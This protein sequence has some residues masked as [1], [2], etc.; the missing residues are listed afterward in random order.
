MAQIQSQIQSAR[1]GV[2]SVCCMVIAEKNRLPMEL[3][4]AEGLLGGA[5]GDTLQSRLI[6]PQGSTLASFPVY[7]T[8]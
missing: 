3:Y 5:K 7:T 1:I 6:V 8:T 2:I 4:D